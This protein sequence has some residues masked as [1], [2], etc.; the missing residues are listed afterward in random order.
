MQ[1]MVKIVLGAAGLG[2]VAAVLFFLPPAARAGEADDLQRMIEVARQGAK[3]LERLD[4]QGL[5]RDETTM[6]GV[7]L[8]GAW[9]LRAQEKY[10]EVR[11]ALDR[12]QAQAEMIHEKLSAAQAAREVAKKE[13][14]LKRLRDEIART[15]ESLQAVAVQKAAL[16]GKPK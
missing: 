15:K 14:E 8:D 16:E 1:R 13:A 5:V 6:L 2:A 7:W 4:D 9:R 3:D 12:V 11:W 10:D